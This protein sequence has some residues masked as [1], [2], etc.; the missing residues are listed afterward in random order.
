MNI[1]EINDISIPQLSAYRSLAIPRKTEGEDIIVESPKVIARALDAGLEPV[2]MLCERKHIE[3]TASEITAR[4]GATPVYTGSRETLA[5]LTGYELTK[6]VLCRMK[7]PPLP[8]PTEILREARRVCVIY[9][10][11]EA[12]NVGVIFRTAAA[13][14]YDAVI[15]SEGSCDP[16]IRRAIRVSMGTVFQIPWTVTGDVLTQLRHH[17]FESV[18][19][20]LSPDSVYLQD[21]R[22]NPDRK[23]AIILGSEGYGLPSDV[24]AAT[25]HV[26]KIP[27][28]HGVDSLNVGAASAIA[29]WHFRR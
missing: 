2:S 26:I 22:V 21:F 16:L 17:G 20:A 15:V 19:M 25:D 5:S 14:G 8:S 18:S 12:T 1:I 4:I 28:H 24:I 29:L 13:L 27:M 11:C 6:G 23:Y 3:G 7:R 9:D 10:V